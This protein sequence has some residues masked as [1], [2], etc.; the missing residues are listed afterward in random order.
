MTGTETALPCG[1]TQ[2]TAR[3]VAH[4]RIARDHYQLSLHCPTMARAAR[5]GQFLHLLCTPSARAHADAGLFLRRPFSLF[6]LDARR[7][8]C[9]LIY[10]VV[11]LGTEALRHVRVGES[12]DLL[13]P[14]GTTFVAD[15]TVTRAVLVGGGVG[16]PPLYLWAKA[17]RT[18]AIPTDVYLGVQTKGYLICAGDFRRLGLAPRIATD[19]GTTEFHG[20]VTDLV[21]RDLRAR[22]PAPGTT[23]YVCGPTPMM[24]AAA[25]LARRWQLPAQVSLE[26]RMGCAMGVCMGCIVEIAGPH[27]TAHKRFQRVCTEG[28]VFDA[29]AVIWRGH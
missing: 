20:Y 23:F 16:I 18:R 29:E 28:P 11:G 26:E 1:M 4:R 14:L 12:L 6:D 21:E 22:R 10:K 15:D 17:L 19:D 25:A 3:V 27:A 5:P 13:G 2:R 9:D 8:T 24:A 7:G